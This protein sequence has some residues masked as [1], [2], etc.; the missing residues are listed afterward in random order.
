MNQDEEMETKQL[1]YEILGDKEKAI[2]TVGDYFD[3]EDVMKN[4]LKVFGADYV[5]GII[6]ECDYNDKEIVI[7]DTIEFL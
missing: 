1:H 5:E 4:I 3:D 6:K 2:K 7:L